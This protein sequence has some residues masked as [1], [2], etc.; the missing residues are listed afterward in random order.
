MP[1]RLMALMPWRPAPTWATVVRGVELP[2]TAGS[3]LTKSAMLGVAD[4]CSSS[5]VTTDTGVGA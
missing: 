2:D 1:R 3:V 4:F 5:T